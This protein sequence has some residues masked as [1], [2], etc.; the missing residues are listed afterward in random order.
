MSTNGNIGIKFLRETFILR[1]MVAGED[2]APLMYLFMCAVL[3]EC[4]CIEL[5]DPCCSLTF[6]KTFLI[7]PCTYFQLKIKG[8]VDDIEVVRNI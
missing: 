6:K 5:M 2:T 1:L 8:N 7:L 4:V 3:R